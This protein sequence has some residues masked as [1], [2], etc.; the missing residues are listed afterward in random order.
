MSANVVRRLKDC[1]HAV[2]AVFDAH[3]PS[4]A[5]LAKELGAEA[6]VHLPFFGATQQ[7]FDRMVALGL[8]GLDKSDVAE[9]TFNG[10]HT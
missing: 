10:R 7:Q 2:T 8:G 3:A 1:G 4:A 6:G 5:S 9:L